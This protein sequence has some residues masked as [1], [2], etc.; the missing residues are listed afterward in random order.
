MLPYP[1]LRDIGK[2]LQFWAIPVHC[3]TGLILLVHAPYF[4]L[5]FSDAPNSSLGMIKKAPSLPSLH[6]AKHLFRHRGCPLQPAVVE[7]SVCSA[8]RPLCCPAHH[9]A[10]LLAR[11]GGCS[12]GKASCKPDASTGG[13]CFDFGACF[14]SSF[15]SYSES[16]WCAP[17]LECVAWWEPG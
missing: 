17:C 10:H 2:Y 5:A 7:F 9:I 13:H 12:R 15:V 1:R 6:V 3:D 14:D 8:P 4:C 16:C 11:P